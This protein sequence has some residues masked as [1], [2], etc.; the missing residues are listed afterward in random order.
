M[1]AGIARSVRE[2][3]RPSSPPLM[4]YGGETVVTMRGPPSGARGGRNTELLLSFA[5]ANAGRNGVWALACD[6]DGI[7]GSGDA[8]GAMVT[9]FSLLRAKASGPLPRDLLDGHRSFQ[10][11][12]AIGDLLRT[13]PGRP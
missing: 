4:L 9:P 12:D 7:D 1:L 5:V 13:G 11:F 2:H 8:A 3:G 10:L 6:T